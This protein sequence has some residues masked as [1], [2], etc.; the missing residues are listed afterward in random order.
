M[1]SASIP[2][3]ALCGQR[4]HDCFIRLNDDDIDTPASQSSPDLSAFPLPVTS[5]I[6]FDPTKR[7]AF[8]RLHTT[9]E[10]SIDAQTRPT[11]FFLDIFPDKVRTLSLH[12]QHAPGPT[13]TGPQ[14][15]TRSLN[16][17]FSGPG[18]MRL[19]APRRVPSGRLH[20]ATPAARSAFCALRHIL[21]Q[22]ALRLQL[23]PTADDLPLD[24]CCQS[25]SMQ[26]LFVNPWQADSGLVSLLSMYGGEGGRVVDIDREL[27]FPPGLAGPG[28]P[29]PSD[30]LPPAYG[31]P[32]SPAPALGPSPLPATPKGK[33]KRRSSSSPTPRSDS[34]T[35][36]YPTWAHL[37][38]AV[39]EREKIMAELLRRLEKKETALNQLM[40]QVDEST[41]RLRELIAVANESEAALGNR[42]PRAGR[43][44][45]GVA[46]QQAAETPRATSPQHSPASTVSVASNIS[47]RVQAY[48]SGR[49]QELSAEIRD[50]GYV[51]SDDVD[52][53]LYEGGYINEDT[54]AEAIEEAVDGAM[55]KVRDRILDAFL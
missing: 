35:P 50:R 10:L 46:S 43:G 53:V 17:R 29:S 40:V 52:T 26:D 24:T 23:P 8:F 51:T 31:P 39:G 6:F 37:N 1:A 25:M 18:A 11:P 3:A 41:C 34:H 54:M 45:G 20:P 55:D 13:T 28:S 49:L 4:I 14:P 30:C 36:N 22:S 19:L 7:N 42:V 9:V 5:R 16:F 27:A 48:V 44:N 38:L 2:R 21:A 47:D 32:A 12:P 33:R 15:K